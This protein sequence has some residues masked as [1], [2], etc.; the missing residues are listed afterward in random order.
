[1]KIQM[2]VEYY[3]EDVQMLPRE[4]HIYGAKQCSTSALT[5]HISSCIA[6]TMF[7]DI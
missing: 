4:M 6:G 1:M 3:L 7:Q 5:T 2:W